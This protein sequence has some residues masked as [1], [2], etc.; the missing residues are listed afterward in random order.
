VPHDIVNCS[1]CG[2]GCASANGRGAFCCGS[3]DKGYQCVVESALN[4]GGCGKM[5]S[6]TQVCCPARGCI[7]ESDYACGPTCANCA[8]TGGICCN[9]TCKACIGPA[10]CLC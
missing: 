9:H 8:A 1:Q 2:Q 7:A 6:S 5:C 3:S 4:C 10:I